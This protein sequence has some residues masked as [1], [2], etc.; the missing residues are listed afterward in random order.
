MRTPVKF[1]PLERWPHKPTANPEKSKFKITP[2]R[3]YEL[4]DLE[5]RKLS[6][7]DVLFQTFHNAGAIRSDG[8]PRSNSY[9]SQPGFILTFKNKSGEILSFPCDTYRTMEENLY[10]VALSLEALRRVDRYGVTRNQEQYRGWKQL[11]SGAGPVGETYD[12]SLAFF[13]DVTDEKLDEITGLCA[14]SEAA[15]G[16]AIEMLYRRAAK[17][18]HPD[19]GGSQADFQRLQEC[20]RIIKDTRQARAEYPES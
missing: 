4:L 16:L 5:L 14:G 18:L 10:A 3:M 15:S 12:T 2:T 6:A 1:V 7:R 20:M 8:Q 17:K 19:M 11:P 9:P 13:A